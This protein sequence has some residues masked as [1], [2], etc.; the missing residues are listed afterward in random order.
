MDD[1]RLP[2]H[3][4]NRIEQRWTARLAQ[5]LE[6]KRRPERTPSPDDRNY[7]P[8]RSPQVR[9]L[10]NGSLRPPTSLSLGNSDRTRTV[11][12]ARNFPQEVGLPD[13]FHF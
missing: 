7:D 3:V 12:G 13:V 2:Q 5:M 8:L 11:C 6:E 9:R 1:I 4:M 10:L